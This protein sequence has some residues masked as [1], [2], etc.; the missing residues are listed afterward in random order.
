[1]AEFES[2]APNADSQNVLADDFR[3]LLLSNPELILADRDLMRALIGAHE[4]E[5]GGNVID[6]RG[7]AMAAL[8]DRLE[9]LE[10]THETVISTAY[11]NQS[12][13]NTIHRAVLALL[14][15]HDFAAFL[16]SLQSRIAPILRIDTLRLVFETGSAAE[17]PARPALQ[18]LPEGMIARLMQAGGRTTPARA[19]PV[20][21]R[22]A[23]PATAAIH[24]RTDAPILSEALMPIDLGAGR[25]PALLVM[26]STEESR[27]LPSHGTD[28]L[29]FFT[30]AFQL[31]LI[32][33]LRE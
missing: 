32:G 20:L 25:R 1:M 7:R 12:G 15:P 6:I 5:I 27:F 8:E 23:A 18:V 21:L 11:E 31:V 30:Q 26:G 9:R 28:L 14:E 24:G 13:M 17:A 16:D 3:Q 33:W 10:V 29:R 19:T 4:A 2:P 22:A